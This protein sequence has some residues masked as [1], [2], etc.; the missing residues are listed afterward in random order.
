MASTPPIIAMGRPGAIVRERRLHAVAT[1][2]EH[3]GER[4]RPARAATAEG[5]TGTTVS[6]RP[7]RS[8]LARNSGKVSSALPSA[9][10]RAPDRGTPRRAGAPR[11]RD[12]GR[13][14]TEPPAC[15]RTQ[16]RARPSTCHSRPDFDTANGRALRRRPHA[17]LYPRRGRESPSR[18]P[19]RWAAPV[20]WRTPAL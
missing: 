8:M 7:A 19:G 3:E 20:A 15:A 13:R 14:R 17:G 11:S 6:A 9:G 10:G 18:T 16:H 4:R 2:D 5:A 1:V 12:G